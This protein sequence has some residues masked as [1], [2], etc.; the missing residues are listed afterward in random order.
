MGREEQELAILV[1][2]KDVSAT[3]VLKGV[4]RELNKLPGIAGKA[5]R[6]MARNLERTVVAG[7]AA[8][9]GAIGYAVKKA[10]DFEAQLNTINTIAREDPLGLAAIGDQV[11]QIARDTGTPLEELTA[12]YYD[13]LSAGIKTADAQQVLVAANKLAIGGLATTAETVDLLTTAINTYGGDATKAAA[14]AD[15]FAKA[16]ERGKVTADEIAASFAIVGPIAASSGIEIQEVAAAYARL[17]AAGV[18]GAEAATQMRSALVGLM[19]VTSPLA[20]L[21]KQTGRNYFAIAGKKGLVYALQLLRQDADKAGVPLIKLLGRVEGVN[22]ALQ[23][24]GPNFDSY[25]ADLAAMG[26]SAGTAAE[27]MSERQ[28]GLNFE[29]ARLKANVDDAA[30]TIGTQLLPVFGDLAAEGTDWLRNHQPEIKAFAQDLAAGI[31]D[32]VQ[33]AK[34]LDWDAIASA[35]QAGAGA[36][37][38]IAEA[39]LGLPAPIQQLLAAGFVAN[40][41]TGGAVMDVAGLVAKVALRQMFVTA[42]IVNVAGGIG[43]G[44]GPGG[45]AGGKGIPTPLKLLGGAGVVLAGLEIGTAAAGINDPRHA[46]G[47]PAHPVMRGTNVPGEQLANLRSAEAALAARAAAGDTF[48]AK[49]LAA[50]RVEIEKL[51]GSTPPWVGPLSERIIDQKAAVDRVREVTESNRIALVAKTDSVRAGV[52]GASAAIVGAIRALDLSPT[53]NIPLTYSGGTFTRRVVTETGTTLVR[54][55]GNAARG[56]IIGAG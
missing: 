48:A 42:G 28:K 7:A 31:K 37:K 38:G 40:K 24:T 16:V 6:N 1:T 44:G 2:G 9:A 22:F 23:T 54:I 27:Q 8:A 19:K 50:V 51:A 12:G 14:Y 41:V 49:Q 45:V 10:G 35:L 34:Q 36:A 21:Q 11:R 39:F 52:A 56:A 15:Y 5:G 32:A 4:N 53:I 13:L 29:M 3:R 26:D 18:P 25:N 17:T 20:K 43:G 47:D 46:T 30:I 33:W 55:G